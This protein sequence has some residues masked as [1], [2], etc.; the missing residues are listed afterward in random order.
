M[1][2]AYRHHRASHAPQPAVIFVEVP[3]A[4]PD[5]QRQA[6]P[7][8]PRQERPAPWKPQRAIPTKPSKAEALKRLLGEFERQDAVVRS[9][10]RPT[11]LRP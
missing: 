2:D 5:F 1:S 8:Y 6:K 3:V 9:M 4:G 11:P 10:M 7:R